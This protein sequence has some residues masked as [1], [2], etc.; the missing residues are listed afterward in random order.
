MHRL[1][2]LD[3][4]VNAFNCRHCM[5]CVAAHQ[6]FHFRTSKFLPRSSSFGTLLGQRTDVDIKMRLYCPRAATGTGGLA[7]VRQGL[8]AACLSGHNDS[9]GADPWLKV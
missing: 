5:T 4:R 9:Q 6:C 2:Q 8:W 1:A 7:P 3:G